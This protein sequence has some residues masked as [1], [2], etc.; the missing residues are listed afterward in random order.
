MN[1][2]PIWKVINLRIHGT[3]NRM[4]RLM[5]RL[6]G[7][8]ES[9]F[10]TC[11]EP[12]NGNEFLYPRT[13]GWDVSWGGRGWTEGGW[14]QVS[15]SR[16]GG[17]RLSAN[18][19]PLQGK[20]GSQDKSW[21]WCFILASISRR[22]GTGSTPLLVRAPTPGSWSTAGRGSAGLPPSPRPSWW[23]TSDPWV[24]VSSHTTHCRCST[25]TWGWPRPWDRSSQWEMF[26][27]IQD[28]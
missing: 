14:C 6:K 7:R 25:G 10:E 19:T 3:V 26:L 2:N 11:S 23:V 17:Y 9:T 13:R 22:P 15:W 21:S 28:F 8:G 1:I 5:K 18:W 27:Q 16:A 20:L 4:Q 24:L 12:D